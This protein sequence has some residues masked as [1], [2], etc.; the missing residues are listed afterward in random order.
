MLP[1]LF[2]AG[3]STVK[4]NDYTSYPQTG[5][6]QGLPLY[7]KKDIAI[8]NRAENGRST[9]SF[10]Q[11]GRLTQIRD[12]LSEGDFLFIQFGHNDEKPDEERH[13]DAFSTYQEYLTEFVQVAQDKKAHPIFITSLYRRLFDENGV[14]IENTHLDYP[15]AMI[16]LGDKLQVPVIDLCKLSKKLIQETGIEQTKDWFMNL[17]SGRYKNFPE[18]K[19]DNSHLQ[20]EGAVTFAGIIATELRKIGGVYKELLLP[21]QLEQED[22]SLLRD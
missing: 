7:L 3:D 2:W 16:E 11:E 6:G 12:E 20:Y 19:E 14:L 9:K 13:T 21:Q 5:M 1:R 4:Q 17:P 8:V 15:Q 22:A 10:I 18:G